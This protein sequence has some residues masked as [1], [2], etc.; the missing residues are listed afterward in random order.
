MIGHTI[1][2]KWN[3]YTSRKQHEEKFII[4]LM[5]FIKIRHAW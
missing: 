2:I 1:E 5:V 3:G 4:F